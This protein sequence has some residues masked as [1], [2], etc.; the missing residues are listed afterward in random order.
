MER[1]QN[2]LYSIGFSKRNLQYIHSLTGF[3]YAP[4]EQFMS[5]NE[6]L[7][8]PE[9]ILS[10]LLG[11]RSYHRK[12]FLEK[13]FHGL[14]MY[15]MK[16]VLSVP[17]FNVNKKCVTYFPI[18]LIHM[19]CISNGSSIIKETIFENRFIHVSELKR[20]GADIAINGNQALVRGK[21]RLL[22]APV[23]AT[24][25][26]ASA[27]LVLA[28]LVAEEGITEINRIYH[29]DRGYEKMEEKFR[30][31]GVKIWRETS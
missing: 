16:G 23:M 9:N 25:L 19:M 10:A 31:L 14:N 20:M 24:D 11:D 2:G 29:L 8:L 13:Y 4:D 22:A 18:N 26:R 12:R 21:E 5:Q 27:S 15:G 17:F 1:I 7:G 3:Y 28:G 30:N 6:V